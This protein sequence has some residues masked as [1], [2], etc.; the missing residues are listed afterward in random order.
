[1]PTCQKCEK[2]V[3]K[4]FPALYMDGDKILLCRE[5]LDAEEMRADME[6]ERQ[7]EEGTFDPDEPG[8]ERDIPWGGDND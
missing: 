4:L 1:M 5:C 7:R 6:Y 3:P 2:E 8:H